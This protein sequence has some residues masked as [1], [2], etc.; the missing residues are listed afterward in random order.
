M[1]QVSII[2]AGTMGH[3]IAQS[4]A[5]RGWQVRLHDVD[6]SIAETAQQRIQTNLNIFIE[7][8]LIDSQEAGD[9]LDR[10]ALCHDLT[11]AVD[12]SELII[13][14]VHEDLEPKR[15]LFITLESLV[16]SRTIFCTNTSAIS[17]TAIGRFLKHRDR[18]LGTHFWN[19]PHIIPC[20]EVIKSPYTSEAVFETVVSIMAGIGKEPIR[21]LK[22]VPGFIGNR[23]QH[24]LQREAMHLV[25]Q[26]IAAPDEVDR[27]VKYGFGLRLAL[28]GP[29]ER[30]DLGG[31]D[32][33][34]RVQKYLLPHLCQDTEPAPLLKEKVD[35][36]HLGAKTGQGFYH[37]SS[38]KRAE[39][40]ALR[41][42]QLLALLKLIHQM[43]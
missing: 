22:D 12:G 9:A 42:R 7:A 18:L 10:V 1:K 21:V 2:G 28:M 15:K 6:R 24:A 32:I 27:V 14:A 5:V 8:G 26:G 43:K 39:T 19:P 40:I 38:E 29:L 16:D 36:G 4:F 17:I 30:A 35:H 41:D 33:T 34:Y 37:W 25:D 11:D 23:M 3:G 31:L 13:E 20:V